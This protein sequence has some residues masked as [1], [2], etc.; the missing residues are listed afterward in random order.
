[1]SSAPIIL[2]AGGGSGGHIFPNLAIA[3][4]LHECASDVSVHFLVSNR[5]LDARVLSGRDLAFTPLPVRPLTRKIWSVPRWMVDWRSSV[6]TVG[7]LIE[8]LDVAGVVATG[9]FVSGPAVVA[10]RRRGIAVGLVNL[11]AVPGKANRFMAR[12]ADRIFSAYDV[13]GWRSVRI[14]V[15]LRRSAIARGPC[16]EARRCLGLAPDLPTL[17]VSGGSQGARTMNDLMAE[18]AGR[19]VPGPGWQV[20]HLSGPSDEVRL[21]DVYEANGVKAVV[22]AF[23][24]QMGL[25][26][27]AATVALS[28]S[29]AGSVAEVW[30]AAVPTV[31]LPYP[32]HADQHQR[33]N[34]LPLV[35][36]GA[37]LL[38]GDRADAPTTADEVGPLLREL[39]INEARRHGM[40]ELMRRRTPKDGAEVVAQWLAATAVE[41]S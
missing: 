16:D 39:M 22:L 33:L 7:R 6:K 19:G 32:F 35:D 1:M 2:F 41:P 15:P 37:A 20:L 14:G 10:A 27:T 25:A 21:R 34:A 11:D 40:T 28:R 30:A 29:G 4:R 13:S 9:G 12:K 8:Q 23:C 17:L 31:F 5:P 36:L 26:W 3:E 24:D 38:V 18:L